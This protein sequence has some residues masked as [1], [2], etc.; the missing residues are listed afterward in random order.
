MLSYLVL[1]LCLLTSV[2]VNLDDTGCVQLDADSLAHYLRGE[3]QILQDAVVYC[4]EG[5]ATRTLLF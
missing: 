2:Q 1:N 3:N 4:G 5:T